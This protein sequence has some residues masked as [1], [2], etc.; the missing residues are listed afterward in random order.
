MN[1][2]SRASRLEP[3]CIVYRYCSHGC[4]PCVMKMTQGTAISF[5]LVLS[6]QVG[7]SQIGH[8][9]RLCNFV[10]VINRTNTGVPFI[11]F[12]M[13]F[14]FCVIL[15]ISLLKWGFFAFFP[16]FLFILCACYIC[17]GLHWNETQISNTKEY[18]LL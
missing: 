10:P 3:T 4:Q 18:T 15:S 1:G 16:K 2:E 6:F 5:V 17:V 9:C 7:S 13:T 12:M 8:L 14:S 11:L